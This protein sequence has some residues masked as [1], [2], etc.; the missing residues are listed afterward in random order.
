MEIGK[1]VVMTEK[2]LLLNDLAFYKKLSISILRDQFKGSGTDKKSGTSFPSGI[3]ARLPSKQL[4]K[5]PLGKDDR[6]YGLNRLLKKVTE[7]NLPEQEHLEQ[8]LRHMYRKNCTV[9]TIVQAFETIRWFMYFLRERGK[10]ALAEI[11]RKDFEAF[12]EFE[13]DRGLKINS[14]RLKMVILRAFF[15]F[16]IEEGVMQDEVLSK[17]IRLMLPELLPRAIEAESLRRLISVIRDTRDRALL[18][19]LL[20]TGMRIGELLETRVPDINLKEQKIMI[21]QASKTE[22]GR[23]V[24]FSNDAGDAL[25]RWLGNRDPS[26]EFL[27]YSNRK[28]QLSYGGA[29]E[30]FRKYLKKAGLLDRGYTLH[31]LRHSFASELLNAGMRLESLQPLL[32]HTNIEATRRYARLTD[33]TREEEYFRAMAII[34]RGEIDG[35]Y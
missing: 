8:Y 4:K 25:K 28:R 1:E 29:R 32:G 3:P 26:V 21:Y 33:K 7:S 19:L 31:R 13:Q 18:L 11:T 5:E 12:I 24:Y 35:Q 17:K 15:R 10:A 34:E 27:F 20:R 14:V 6:R 16:L 22:I 23:V 30:I 2:R 9:R